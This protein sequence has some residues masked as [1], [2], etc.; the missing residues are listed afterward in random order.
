MC[1]VEPLDRYLCQQAN[2]DK[3]RYVSATFILTEVDSIAV[4]LGYY[5]LSA[6]SVE[7]RNIPE[8][9][10]KKLPKYPILPA[11]LLGR[12]AVD[13]KF[14]RKGLG[15]LL[16]M[17]ALKRSLNLSHSVASMAVVVDAK[18]AAAINFYKNYG[19]M[20]FSESANR[21]FLPMSAIQKIP[22]MSSQ[23][24]EA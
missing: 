4:V 18:D 17:D 24:V 6:T 3:K 7:L 1:G 21:L 14:Q 8:N 12:L 5:T 11:T 2:Q 22:S 19:F 9:L 16:L 10:Q 20:L 23:L 13:C 15:E